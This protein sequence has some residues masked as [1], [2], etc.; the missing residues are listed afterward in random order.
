[1]GERIL[2][3]SIAG[4][5]R[6]LDHS[7]RELVADEQLIDDELD[8]LCVQ[9]DVASPI[10]FEAQ[11]ARRLRV[12]LG[13]DII[14]LGPQRVCRVL[15]LEILHQPGAVELAA[16]EVAGKRGKPAPAQKSAAVAHWIFSVHATPIGQGRTGDNDGAEQFGAHRGEHHDCPSALTV[17]DDSGL[18]VR[19]RVQRAIT[20]SRKIASA[21]R[22]VLDCLSRH[23][24][25]QKSDE[26]TGVT[27]LEDHSDF[28]IG[29]ETANAG[30]MAGAR[31]RR[32]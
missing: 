20:F 5:V 9:I 3:R 7:R 27:R 13:I 25:G 24:F 10:A 29:L 28:A 2:R 1:M 31:D 22:N 17:A 12:D 14:L 19:V 8:L 11:I 26:I 16:A 32:S 23:G 30:A 18:A 4:A 21:R 6:R 15:V